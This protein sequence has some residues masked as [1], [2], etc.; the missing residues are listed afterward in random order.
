MKTVGE[1]SGR[2]SDAGRRIRCPDCGAPLTIPDPEQDEYDDYGDDYEEEYRPRSRR[3]KRKSGRSRSARSSRRRAPELAD[4][5]TRFVA[6][7]LDGFILAGVLVPVMFMSGYMDKF[8]I[9]RQPDFGEQAVMSLIGIVIFYVL[10]GFFLVNGQT[11]GKKLL[12][13]QI[14]D[15]SGDPVSFGKLVA[16]RYLPMQIV[17]NIPLAGGILGLI[18]VLLIFGEDRRCGHDL[19]CGTMVVKC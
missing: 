3:P 19:I 18:N 16:L 10:H 14:V 5:G 4:R 17:V 6:A 15:E 7:L 9:D 8:G 1:E 2:E 12:G 13:I 11:I